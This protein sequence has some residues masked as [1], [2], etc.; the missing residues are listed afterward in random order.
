MA[1]RRPQS[2]ARTRRPPS[3]VGSNVIAMPE[4]T[5]TPTPRRPLEPPEDPFHHR[6]RYGRR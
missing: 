2:L 5:G 6:W 4:Y 3:R 1:L